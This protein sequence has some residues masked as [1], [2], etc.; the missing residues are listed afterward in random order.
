MTSLSVRSGVLLEPERTIT[1]ERIAAAG[2]AP[3]FGVHL[4]LDGYGG[5]L[6]LLADG[7]HVQRCLSELPERLSARTS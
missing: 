2:P 3:C 1:I 7:E 4:T 6:Q 5:S